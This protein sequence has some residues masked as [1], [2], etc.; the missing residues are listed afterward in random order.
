M[1]WVFDS[2][3]LD[4]SCTQC[5][6]WRGHGHSRISLCT[7]HM[8]RRSCLS[9]LGLQSWRAPAGSCSPWGPS[10]SETPCQAAVGMRVL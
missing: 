7:S 6:G 9:A 10:G 1:F 2:Y 3:H 8:R 5:L 4:C